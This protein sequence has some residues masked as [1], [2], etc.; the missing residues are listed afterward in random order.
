[1]VLLQLLATGA[2]AAL[3]AG[4]LVAAARMRTRRHLNQLPLITLGPNRL[5]V[6]AVISPVGATIVKLVAPAADGAPVDVALGFER[7]ATYALLK[8]TPY[9]GAVV[10]RVA[11]RI[12]KVSDRFAFLGPCLCCC[13]C[14]CCSF[15]SLYTSSCS[16]RGVVQVASS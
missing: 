16:V 3:S 5:G 11:N 9:F 15:V 6:S 10:G 14:C 8:G 13:C 4:A 12:A 1:M 7:A 2:A